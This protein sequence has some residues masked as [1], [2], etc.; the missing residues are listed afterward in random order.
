MV[1][2]SAIHDWGAAPD[3]YFMFDAAVPLEAYDGGSQVEPEMEPPDWIQYQPRVWASYWYHN[4]SLPPGDGRGL[5][6]WKNRLGRVGPNVFNFYSSSEDVLRL[7]PGQPTDK[8]V[9]TTAVTQGR[10]AWAVQ[11]KL[12]GDQISF[13]GA[14]VGTQYGGWGFSP[15]FSPHPD[16]LANI[17]RTL[18][19]TDAQ[20]LATPVFNPGFS[21]D[22]G[23]TQNPPR[24]NKE[25]PQWF[26][27]LFD[28]S[29]A[30]NTA[31]VHLNQLLGEAI[32]A[33]TLPAGANPVE[34]LISSNYNMPNFITDLGKW[35]RPASYNGVREWR[36]SDLKEMSYSYMYN[37]FDKVVELGGLN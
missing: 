29:K 23:N 7:Q 28:S 14:K 4:T 17:N 21:Y 18:N 24:P 36:H 2:G 6:T 34:K 3:N 30:S 9:L 11:E 32:P 10:Y 8:T 37:L 31:S 33:L 13:P 20:L 35:P 19:T 5:L 12:K 16:N 25:T 27:D 22:D 26:F 1:V 15:N